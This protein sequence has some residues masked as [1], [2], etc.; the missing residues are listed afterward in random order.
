MPV[1]VISGVPV[2]AIHGRRICGSALG[3]TRKSSVSRSSTPMC[4]FSAAILSSFFLASLAALT[5]Q[6]PMVIVPL[7]PIIPAS[8]PVPW[9]SE[10]TSWTP[11]KGTF[12]T[13]AT[14]FW[15][16][17]RWAPPVSPIHIS[18]VTL[19]KGWSFTNPSVGSSPISA[20]PCTPTPTPMARFPSSLTQVGTSH[21]FH[22][23]FHPNLAADSSNAAVK[24]T[25]RT[26]HHL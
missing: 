2:I 19:P 8:Y 3:N 7:E 9:V 12:M 4:S 26:S 21:P 10:F 15:M 23:S 11:S 22:L 24:S 17:W 13:S 25:E 14:I 1:M 18:T 5:A 16:A 6:V 20:L